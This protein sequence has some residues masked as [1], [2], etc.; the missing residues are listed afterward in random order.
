VADGIE[1]DQAKTLSGL[2][3][4]LP[5]GRPNPWGEVL[6]GMC[7]MKKISYTRVRKAQGHDAALRA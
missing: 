7:Y 1:I 5:P 2:R 4:V 6:K 3:I